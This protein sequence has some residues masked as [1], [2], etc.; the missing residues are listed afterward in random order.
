LHSPGNYIDIVLVTQN[1]ITERTG[2]EA[3]VALDQRHRKVRAEAP[4]VA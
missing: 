4:Q 1:S 2:H 3:A